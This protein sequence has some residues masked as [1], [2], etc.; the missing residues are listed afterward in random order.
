MGASESSSQCQR[1]RFTLAAASCQSKPCFG[2]WLYKIHASAAIAS[3][4]PVSHFQAW[5]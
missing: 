1:N 5:R 2:H 4:Q 3:A